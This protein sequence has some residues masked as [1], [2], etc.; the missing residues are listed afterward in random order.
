[1]TKQRVLHVTPRNVLN[2]A[3]AIA[4]NSDIRL[5][6]DTF[7][8]AVPRDLEPDLVAAIEQITDH[9][10]D[11]LAE[12]FTHCLDIRELCTALSKVLPT[13]IFAGKRTIKIIEDVCQD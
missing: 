7:R 3:F 4:F 6:P 11:G 10:C 2:R 1:M 5:L 8:S 13:S 12:S 9:P